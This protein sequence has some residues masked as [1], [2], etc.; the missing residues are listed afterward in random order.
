MRFG[1]LVIGLREVFMASLLYLLRSPVGT[2]SRALFSEKDSDATLIGIEKAVSILPLEGGEVI[3][4]GK[5]SIFSHKQRLTWS[6][7]LDVVF[8]EDKVFI[9]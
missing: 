4:Q 6:E 5:G 3:V 2:I 1:L 8:Q 7:V 9:L